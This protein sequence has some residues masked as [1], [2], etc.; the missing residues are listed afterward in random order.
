MALMI[1]STFEEPFGMVM[2][3]ALACGTPVIGWDTGAIPEVV[4]NGDNGLL[5]SRASGLT[6]LAQAIGRIGAIDRALCRMDFEQ[7]FTV[8][9]MVSEHATVYANLAQTARV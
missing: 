5:V 1:P 8:E 7:R 3:E 6:G 4:R 9:R 2:I